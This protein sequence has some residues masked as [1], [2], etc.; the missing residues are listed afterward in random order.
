[1]S[2]KQKGII[3]ILLSAM[4]FGLMN[5]FVRLSGNIPSMQKSVFRNLIAALIAG[6]TLIKNKE[7][8]HYEKKDLPILLLR[9]TCGTI[10]ILCNF[11]AVDHMNL[12][13]SSALQ[14]ITPFIVIIASHFILKE[15]VKLPQIS[16]ILLAF[17]GCLFVVKPSFNMNILPAVI[18]LTGAI[19]S[20]I[21]YTMVR[22][23]GTKGVSKSKIVFFFSAFSCLVVLP[24]AI[25][26]FQP[27]T[28][29][30]V[31]YLVLAGIC[32]AG[33]QFSVTSAY[34]Y[35]P[36]KEISVF[37]YT[38][39]IFVAILS[40]FIFDQRP[41]VYSFIGYGIIILCGYLN[42]LYTNKKEIRQ[43]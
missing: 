11:Y 38:Q 14:K 9:A 30:Q 37:D 23:L 2:N 21:A 6:I 18:A 36:S 41:D 42:Y 22:I 19:G 40:F 29:I 20:G 27:M 26:D 24:F 31:I 10:G 1:M 15:K 43:C 33:G 28:M 34:S 13:D 16:M 17:I 5:I 39:I 25:A 12:A 32:A 35:A 3:C 7:G 8:F 4:C